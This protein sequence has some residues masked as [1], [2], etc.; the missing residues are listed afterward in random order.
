MNRDRLRGLAGA[1]AVVIVAMTLGACTSGKKKSA[2]KPDEGLTGGMLVFEDDF[3][4]QALGDDWLQR[5]G[6]W[7]LVDGWVHVQGDR[8]EGLWLNRPL[9]ERV[10]IEFDARS[11]SDDGDLKFEVFCT[12]QRHQTGY[13]GILGGWQNSISIIARLDEHGEDRKESD[14]QVEIG[15]THRFMV[16]RTDD[17]LRFY[18][19][20]RFVSQ[21]KDPAPIRGAYFGFNNWASRAYYDNLA[22]YQLP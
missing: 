11:E 7:R 13:I 8:N 9:P 12:E 10:R 3:E 16:V 14:A 18:V 22:I 5:S 1:A 4:R 17:T 15:K 6:K 19:D 20:G 2:A 21:Y